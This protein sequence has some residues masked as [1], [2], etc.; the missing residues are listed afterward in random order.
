[1]VV[2]ICSVFTHKLVCHIPLDVTSA[3]AED[4]D[5]LFGFCLVF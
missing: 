1:M 3:K 2:C 5:E 4:N